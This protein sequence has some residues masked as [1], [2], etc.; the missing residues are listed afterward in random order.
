MDQNNINKIR[1]V[2]VL[3]C[4]IVI[5]IIIL[6][7][8]NYNNQE[9]SSGPATITGKEISSLNSK[10]E[11]FYGINKSEDLKELLQYCIENYK[12]YHEEYA[13]VPAI[14]YVT[15]KNEITLTYE[16]E[17]FY[18]NTEETEY[19]TGLNNIIQNITS[20]KLYKVEF[21]YDIQ[22]IIDNVS[23]INEVEITEVEQ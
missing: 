5:A 9:I 20:D 13:K 7:I 15:E 2:I 4:I 16:Y 18:E 14:R 10:F 8:N 12:Y 1:N 19:Y 6:L 22:H 21:K 23:L 17:N 3:F 11:Q